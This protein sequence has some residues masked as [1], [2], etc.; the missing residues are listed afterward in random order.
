MKVLPEYYQ[1]QEILIGKEYFNLG[2]PEL[3]NESEYYNFYKTNHFFYNDNKKIHER[4]KTIQ[5][6]IK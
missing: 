4:N 3:T 6:L 5:N 2:K 1:L